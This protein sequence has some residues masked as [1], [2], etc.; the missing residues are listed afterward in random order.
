MTEEDQLGE[1]R[2]E[3]LQRGTPRTHLEHGGV[4]LGLLHVW[5]QSEGQSDCRLCRSRDA[6]CADC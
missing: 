5:M 1:Q 3:G 2:G 4:L 6:S